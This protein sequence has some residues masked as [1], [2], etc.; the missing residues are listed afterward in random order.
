MRRRLAVFS[1]LPILLSLSLLSQDV[2]VRGQQVAADEPL[3]SAGERS[4]DV[5]YI[6]LD[7]K[8]DLPKK[9]VDGEA[10]ISFRTLR[11]LQEFRLD[12]VEFTVSAVT[13][14]LDKKTI[15]TCPG[16]NARSYAL[17]LSCAACYP[18]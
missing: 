13:L 3:R 12:A 17:I 11:D 4:I 10:T 16:N 9:T 6:R 8:V 18:A 2:R 15:P 14:T 5:K 7:L 1:M